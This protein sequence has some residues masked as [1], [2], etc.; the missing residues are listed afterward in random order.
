LTQDE[1]AAVVNCLADRDFQSLNQSAQ[2]AC[3]PGPATADCLDG[4]AFDI[5]AQ[6][7]KEIITR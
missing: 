3:S 4:S 2:T 5:H 1:R 7:V 6:T